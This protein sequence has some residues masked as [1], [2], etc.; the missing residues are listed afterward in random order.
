[1]AFCVWCAAST[2]NA[3]DWV[4]TDP[5]PWPRW[6]PGGR[7]VVVSECRPVLVRR[8]TIYVDELGYEVY[9]TVSYRR[10]VLCESS[11]CEDC[12]R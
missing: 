5:P 7:D 1:M 9:R 10:A 4:P 6:R 2:V 11:R 8:T 3:A 12:R